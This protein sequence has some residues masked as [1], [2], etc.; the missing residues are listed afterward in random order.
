[1][2]NKRDKRIF[3]ALWT[4]ATAAGGALAAFMEAGGWQFLATLVFTGFF[5]GAA[6]WPILWRWGFNAGW[7]LL[8]GVGWIMGVLLA[9]ALP[10]GQLATSLF[11]QYG[12]WEVFWLNTLNLP[13]W[14]LPMLLLQAYALRGRM[15]LLLWLLM[16][17]LGAVCYG[18]LSAT[19]CLLLCDALPT[20]IG[21]TLASFGAW[22]VFGALTGAA[23]LNLVAEPRK[24]RDTTS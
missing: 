7:I 24:T 17:L 10:T 19:L 23:L 15:N 13:L 9:G 14:L 16:G 1:M 5:I 22:S 18:M 2:G 21:T 11:E 12:M 20:L 6:Q 4:G 8:S 3:F